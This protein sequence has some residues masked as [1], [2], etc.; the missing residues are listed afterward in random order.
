MGSHWLQTK[1]S[2]CGIA[3]HRVWLLRQPV[4][5][6]ASAGS[7]RNTGFFTAHLLLALQC[8]TRPS[9]A[10]TGTRGC[11]KRQEPAQ[12]RNHLQDE[13]R[14]THLMVFPVG[15]LWIDHTAVTSDTRPVITAA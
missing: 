13:C 10:V 2:L 12:G 14:K 1:G 6:K 7:S 4:K 15:L 9:F 11:P 3:V 8:G 5:F